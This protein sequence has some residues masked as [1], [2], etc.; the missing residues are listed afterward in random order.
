VLELPEP[1]QAASAVAAATSA[2]T[3][4]ALVDSARTF[5]MPAQ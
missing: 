3:H 2:A 1:P 5:L 4:P